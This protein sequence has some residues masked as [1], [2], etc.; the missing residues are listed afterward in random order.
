MAELPMIA[1]FGFST[2]GDAPDLTGLDD[3]LHRVADSGA[4]HAEL[5]VCA[6]DIVAGGRVI[7]ERRRVLERICGRHDL[8]YTIHGALGVNFM[9]EANL[10]I[11][12][13]VCMAM[14]E[15]AEA[16]GAGIMVHHPGIVR[17]RDEAEIERLHA[18]EREVLAEMGE[19]ARGRGVR[20]A[21]ETLFADAPGAYTADPMR[22]AAELERLGHPAVAG[23]LDFSHSYLAASQRGLDFGEALRR[24]APVT[25][26]LHVHDSFGRPPSIAGFHSVS[27]RIAFGMGDLHLPMGW[28]DIPFDEL[29]DELRFRPGTVL[30]VELPDRHWSQLEEVAATARGLM[31]RANRRAPLPV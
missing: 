11:H 8:T 2:I 19:V 25:N 21:V 27:E 30:I 18:L 9:D 15:L 13:Q 31:E 26:H 7:P 16:V 10:T 4:S 24:F 5:S 20:I 29:F 17:G 23:T 22:L 12:K 14:L 6:A 1:G 28:G 3:A